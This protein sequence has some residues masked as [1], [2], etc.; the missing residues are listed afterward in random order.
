MCKTHTFW[1][2]HYQVLLDP[3]RTAVPVWGQTTQMLRGL[4]PKRDCGPKRVNTAC[5]RAALL[6]KYC[7][8]CTLFFLPLVFYIGI[9][10]P[11]Y[12]PVTR[13]DVKVVRQALPSA[14][15]DRVSGLA[16]MSS[17]LPPGTY[18]YLH[19]D[20]AM[21]SA[22]PR[23]VDL[24]RRSLPTRRALSPFRRREKTERK[25]IKGVWGK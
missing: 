10:H 8:C 12:F 13:T 14:I 19:F 9:C 2:D 11:L 16:H 7:G 1:S 22:F 4:S 25:K 21:G 3:F 6:I 5:T 20:R 23:L 17:L 24:H 18:I 15:L